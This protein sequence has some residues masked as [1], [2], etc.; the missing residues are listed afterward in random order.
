MRRPARRSRSPAPKPRRCRPWRRRPRAARRP[1]SP[2]RS[3]WSPTSA[4]YAMRGSPTTPR[5]SRRTRRGRKSTTGTQ[6]DRRLGRYAP[7][8][9]SL[10]LR[11]E[12]RV[13]DGAVL[14]QRGGFHQ[15]VVPVH[16]ERLV[17]LVDHGLDERK[18]IAGIKPRRRSRDAAG[19]VGV[20]D[21]LDA[22]GIDDLAGFG[23]LDIAAA[24]D[25]EINQHRT[26]LHRLHHLGTDE[27]WRRTSR[28]Q[29]GG[30]DDVL[31][32]DMLGGGRGLLALVPLCIFLGVAAG[33]LGLL[34]F[35]VLAREGLCAATLDLPFDGRPPGRRGGRG[36]Q[37]A[38]GPA[39]RRA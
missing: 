28:D 11:L 7:W 4:A 13:D 17:G 30:E 35:L 14:G 10:G 37:P 8:L 18:Q 25:R 15:F 19:D 39:R 36:A 31:L 33:G 20:A 22:V 21:D 12:V 2:R 5:N 3:R 1:R 6:R 27:L 32:L 24:L 23:A 29:R 16:R 34:E 9:L 26:R 38:R